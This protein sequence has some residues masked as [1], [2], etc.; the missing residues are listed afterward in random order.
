MLQEKEISDLKRKLRLIENQLRHQV[1]SNT[2]NIV[3]SIERHLEEIKILVN[4]LPQSVD[5]F[6]KFIKEPLGFDDDNASENNVSENVNIQIT[7]HQRWIADVN[8]AI[9]EIKRVARSS[10]DHIKDPVRTQM[11]A[12][13]GTRTHTLKDY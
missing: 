12:L 10:E 7:R 9:T 3:N 13:A 4:A 1:L 5:E 8:L 6:E 11:K 2:D